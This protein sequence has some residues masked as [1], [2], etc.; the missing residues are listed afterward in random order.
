[1]IGLDSLYPKQGAV[2]RRKRVG[3]GRGSGH[4]ETS[5]KGQKGQSARSG[6]GRDES[7]E[8]GQIPL[9]RRIPKSGF[10]NVQF[11]KRYEWVN[12]ETLAKFPA[13]SEINPETLKKSGAVKC[14]CLVK[15]LGHGEI[16]HAVKVSAH[17]FSKSA[18]EKIE[19]AGGTATLIKAA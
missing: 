3:F 4:G 14:A 6:N 17:A 13:N 8:G 15:V 9:A 1:M 10:S 2:H 7:M 5:T 12:L 11:E 16:K 19:K 18:K